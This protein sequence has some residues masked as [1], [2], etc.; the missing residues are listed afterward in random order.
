MED[1]SKKMKN[2]RENKIKLESIVFSSDI[3]HYLQSGPRVDELSHLLMILMN[4][5]FENKG[6]ST[7]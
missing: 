1:K 6:Y 2:K 4:S 5:T 3:Q 7:C